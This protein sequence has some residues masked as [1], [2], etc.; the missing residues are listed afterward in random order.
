MDLGVG[1]FRRVKS[2][3]KTY[4][5]KR[6]PLWAFFSHFLRSCRQSPMAYVKMR[7]RDR[8]GREEMILSR[9]GW[10]SEQK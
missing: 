10:A 7:T 9:P 3:P 8:E 2:E 4:T 1:T 5:K 6:S